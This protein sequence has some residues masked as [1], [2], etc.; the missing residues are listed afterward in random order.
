MRE[1]A[2]KTELFDQVKQQAIKLAAMFKERAAHTDSTGEFPYENFQAL[3]ES[4][5]LSL[6][7]P[8]EYGGKGL[9]LSEYLQIQEILAQGDAATALSFGWQL[10]VILENAENRKWDEHSF[11]DLSYKIVHDKILLN[12]AQTENA[13]GSP[14]RGAAPTT[15]ASSEGTKWKIN[16]RKSFASIAAALDYS[17]V[18]AT[19]HPSGNKGFFLIDHSLEGVAVEET[20]DSIAM[21]GTRSDDI[22][23]DDVLVDQEALLVEENKGTVTPRGWYLQIAAVY[24]GIAAAARD[25]TIQFA[26]ELRPA[27]L[28]GPIKEVPEVRRKIGEIELALFNAREVLYATARKWIDYPEKRSAMSPD[29]AAAKHIVTNNANH[30]V[31]LCMRI[32]GARSLS[33]NNPLQRHFRDVRAGLHNPPTDD[34]VVYT[35]A[36]HAL[37]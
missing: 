32:A 23:L 28:P 29:L 3:K 24:L 16:G 30:V 37:K 12:L 18:T 36:D 27:S 14:S 34:A 17:I 25:Y 5:F 33:A 22:I 10:G 13:T 11:Q 9:N 2:E 35:L 1:T 4:N 21:R 26:S 7:V 8:P 20:W 31:D 19:I 15:I 6:T